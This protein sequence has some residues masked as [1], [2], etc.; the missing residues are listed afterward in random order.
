MS[1]RLMA[2]AHGTLGMLLE[3]SLKVLPRPAASVTV[4]RECSPAEAIASMS[5]W[6]GKPYPVD[7]ACYHGDP[8]LRAHLRQRTGR[9]GSAHEDTR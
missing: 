6:L 4:A 2:G 5:A 7:G 1:L 9:Q 3:I 8:M